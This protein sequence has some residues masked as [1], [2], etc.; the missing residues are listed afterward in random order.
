MSK[1]TQLLDLMIRWQEIRDQGK[2]ITPEELC[3]DCP[4]MVEE[5]RGQID[6]MGAIGF[7]T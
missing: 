6:F 4:E 5:V 3:T 1:T 2:V 7:D